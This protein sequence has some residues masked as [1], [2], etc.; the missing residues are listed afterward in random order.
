LDYLSSLKNIQTIRLTPVSFTRYKTK[1]NFKKLMCDNSTILRINTIVED[2]RKKFNKNYI[3]GD[4]ETQF[5]KT[6]DYQLDNQMFKRRSICTGNLRSF[7]I[8]PNGDVTICEQM[9]WDKHF[10]IG[11]LK[12]DNIMDFWNSERAKNFMKYKMQNMKK[13][14][15][16]FNC[17]DFIKCHTTSGICWKMVVENYT[18][19][20]WYY[21]DPRCPKSPDVIN[22]Y[23][24]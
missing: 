24:K 21:P 5:F 9:Y 1:E 18:S 20:K 12:T 7:F 17:D 2:Y 3:V 6:G 22:N 15:K 23:T 10:I 11:N 19:D 13:D 8:L 14:S 4:N 16:C